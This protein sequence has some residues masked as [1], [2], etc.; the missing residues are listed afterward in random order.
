[1]VAK[2][3]E[4]KSTKHITAPPI[5]LEE[6]EK[7]VERKVVPI[8]QV[9]EVVEDEDTSISQFPDVETPIAVETDSTPEVENTENNDTISEHDTSADTDRKSVV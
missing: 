1:M 9:V 4:T 5:S 8:T 7:K 3:K 2:K 6:E